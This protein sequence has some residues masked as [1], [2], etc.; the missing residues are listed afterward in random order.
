MSPLSEVTPG[1]TA[2]KLVTVRE[3]TGGHVMPG[4]PA[5]YGTVMMILP[6]E[7]AAGSAIQSSLTVRHV[8]VGMMV[9]IRILRQRRSAAGA[10]GC[11][12]R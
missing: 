8:S 9:N 10:R 5:V 11:T 2:E 4:M 1:M 12:G 6:M 3:M 7:M